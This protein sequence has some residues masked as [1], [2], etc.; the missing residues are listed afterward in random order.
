M[1]RCP[2]VTAALL[3]VLPQ[4]AHPGDVTIYESLETVSIGRVFL[5]PEERRWLDAR[6]ASEPS[7][8]LPPR[9]RTPV[10]APSEPAPARTKSPAGYIVSSSGEARV[11]RDGEFVRS[12]DRT[13]VDISFP[14]D[15]RVKRHGVDAEPL[16]QGDRERAGYA[17]TGAA[18]AAPAADRV[19]D[20]AD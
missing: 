10:R 5:S 14:G 15:V 12:D 2:F 16:S 17:G 19:R 20:D 6:R 9:A 8:V 3:L 13:A 1:S 4:L 11:W 18:Q 7:A